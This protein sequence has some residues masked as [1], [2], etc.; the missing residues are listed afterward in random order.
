MLL[1]VRLLA[2]ERLDKAL[3]RGH[4]TIEPAEIGRQHE[5]ALSGCAR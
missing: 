5:G 2:F 1:A 4:T 3:P